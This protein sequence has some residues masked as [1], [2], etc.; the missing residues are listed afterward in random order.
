MELLNI[1]PKLT[2]ADE[3]NEVQFSEAQSILEISNENQV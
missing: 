2:Y 1:M 3:K